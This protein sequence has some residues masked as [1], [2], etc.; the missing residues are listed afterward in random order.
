MRVALAELAPR[1][2]DP[3]A[4]L[5]RLAA[6]VRAAGDRSHRNCIYSHQP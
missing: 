5:A 6:V 3:A 2:A 4:N 1:P